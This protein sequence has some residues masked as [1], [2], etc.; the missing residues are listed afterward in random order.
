M[1]INTSGLGKRGIRKVKNLQS[2]GKN[3]QAQKI[4]R[5]RTGINAKTGNAAYTNTPA[6]TSF[7]GS[8]GS[9]GQSTLPGQNQLNPP[10]L[11]TGAPTTPPPAAAPPVNDTGTNNAANTI[12]PNSRMFEEENYAGSP[13]YQFQL[14]EGNKQLDRSLAKR[15]LSQSGAGIVEEIGMNNRIAAQDTDRMSRVAEGNASRL[16]R[17]QLQESL[18]QE[19][20]GNTAFDQNLSIAELM[21]RSDPF[22]T[23][24]DG[25]QTGAKV[26]QA[27]ATRHA[28]YLRSLYDLMGSG[29]GGGAAAPGLP[30][31]GIPSGPDNSGSTLAGVNADNA[32]N[33]DWMKWLQQGLGSYLGDGTGAK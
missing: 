28:A 18:R 14:K 12:F 33:S 11:D 25:K 3:R 19:R 30:P 32:S 2:Q 31:L 21:S 20:A 22:Q 13:L 4:A 29:G 1:P 8:L 5:R 24:Y 16:E 6:T 10:S 9:D 27:N 23:A 15:G 17:M 26:K 7:G